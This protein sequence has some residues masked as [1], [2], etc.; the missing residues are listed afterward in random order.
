[1]I[2]CQISCLWMRPTTYD[3]WH[4]STNRIWR[5]FAITAWYG[6]HCMQLTGDDSDYI[7]HKLQWPCIWSKDA[8]QQRVFPHLRTQACHWL[9]SGKKGPFPGTWEQFWLTSTL[10]ESPKSPYGSHWEYSTITTKS[11]ML[12]LSLDNFQQIPILHS[13]K[14]NFARLQ[15]SRLFKSEFC[16][17]CLTRI[18]SMLIKQGVSLEQQ[19]SLS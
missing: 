1:M 13:Y 5:Q 4:V 9:T 10:P 11:R 3:S 7:T 2:L 17:F 8:F 19:T 15:F 16:G 18:L 6:R 14:S 12:Q